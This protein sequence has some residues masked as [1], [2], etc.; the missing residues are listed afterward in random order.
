MNEGWLAFMS[1]CLYFMML[2]TCS[3]TTK[4]EIVNAEDIKTECINEYINK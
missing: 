2:Q 4:I 3:G 1:L